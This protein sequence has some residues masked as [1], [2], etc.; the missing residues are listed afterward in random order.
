MRL[1]KYAFLSL[2]LLFSA[3]TLTAQSM[4]VRNPA[5]YLGYGYGNYNW[6]TMTGLFDAKFGASNITTG[7]EITSLAG[8]TSL[9]LDANQPY[10]AAYNLRAAERAEVASF[11][12]AGGRIYGFGENDAW[13][14]WNSDLLSIFGAS[15]GSLG[16]DFGTPLVAN[17]L[18]AGVSSIDTPAPG[19]IT[20]FNGG[21]NLFSNSIAGL[22]GNDQGLVV[23]DIN[24]CDDTYINQADNRRFCENIVNFT[25]GAPISSVP[26]P[27]S[28]ALMALGVLGVATAA[29]RRRSA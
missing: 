24:I 22:L 1:A 4:F 3:Q 27:S 25:A 28:L 17:S 15:G 14:S 13:S 19:M 16:M 10:T 9:Y 6:N 11:L 29:R 26:E 8:Y 12:A 18:T 20:D 5:Q 2:G 23:L 21:T 7:N